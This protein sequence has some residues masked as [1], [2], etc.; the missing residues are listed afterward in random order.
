MSID[1]Y[2]QSLPSEYSMPKVALDKHCYKI[3]DK[4]GKPR[5][6]DTSFS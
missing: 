6:Y 2:T 5:N 3:K 4:I 1:Q